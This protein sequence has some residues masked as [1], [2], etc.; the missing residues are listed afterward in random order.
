M[1][2]THRP[3]FDS[4]HKQIQIAAV[5]WCG[6]G[7]EWRWRVT[8]M[9]RANCTVFWFEMRAQSHLFT[10]L[11]VSDNAVFEAARHWK[12]PYSNSNRLMLSVV[13]EAQE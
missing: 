10:P 3:C 6:G 5:G 11:M 7:V 8:S 12:D 1:L 13:V 9:G 2:L 4:T